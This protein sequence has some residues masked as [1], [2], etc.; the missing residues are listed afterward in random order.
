MKKTDALVSFGTSGQAQS[1]IKPECRRCILAKLLLVEDDKLLAGELVGFLKS[2]GF[3]VDHVLSAESAV[4]H[5]RVY[6]YDLIILDWN[7]PGQSGIDFL[8]DYRKSGGNLPTLMLTGQALDTQV[9]QGLDGGADDY[10]IKPFEPR[11]LSARIRALLRRPEQINQQLMHIAGLEVDPENFTV[12]IEGEPIKL[13]RKEIEILCYLARRKGHL[14]SAAM[15][16]SSLWGA[17]KEATEYT[18]RQH[19]YSLRKKLA[20]NGLADLIETVHGSGYRLNS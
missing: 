5:L 1:I 7:L 13:H 4:D 3:E 15:L 16:L 10:V 19:I 12:K 11:I 8:S 18:V 9:E 14:I 6:S 17:E 20:S 2:K